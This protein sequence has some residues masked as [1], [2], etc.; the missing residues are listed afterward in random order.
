MSDKPAL[1]IRIISFSELD[2][3]KGQAIADR[4]AK[5]AA[6]DQYSLSLEKDP[7]LLGGLV[8][9]VGDT[10]YDYSIKGQLDQLAS[11]FKDE[12]LP[13]PA[14]LD[15]LPELTPAVSETGQVISYSDGVALVRGLDNCQNNELIEFGSQAQ[16]IAMNLASDHVGVVVLQQ[17]E[18]IRAGM[19]C[20]RTKTTV[21]VPAGLELLGR[22]LDPL[23]QP[24]DGRGKL[25]A[26]SYWPL[27]YPAAG[28]IER[29][30]VN[31]PLQTGITALDAL[32]PIGRGQRELIIG[33][34]QT[35]KTALVIDTIL[36]QKNQ[37]VLCIYVAIGQ[38]MSTVAAVVKLLEEKGAMAYT[39]VVVA[40]ASDTPAMQYV[41]AYAGCAMA[42]ALMYQ[43]KKDVLVVYD[44]LTKHAQ[45][46]RA[47]SLLLRRPP[48]REAYP[49]DIFYLHA[50]LLERSTHLSASL[51][52]GSMTALPVVETQS[53]DISAYIPTN[54]ISITDGQIYLE[55][56]LFFSGQRP[57]V[58][59]GLSVS[60]VGG[61]AQ[62]PA[63]KKVAGPLRINL[64][65]YRSLAAFARF[66]SELDAQTQKQ[67]Q[68][69]ERLLE[70]L[71]QPQY[72]PLPVAEQ[73][74]MLYLANRGAMSD[75]SK[76][77][78]QPFLHDFLFSLRETKADLLQQLAAGAELDE[79]ISRQL[80]KYVAAYLPRWQVEH[81][82]YD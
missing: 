65:Q 21:H 40:S 74:I 61:A 75:L 67:L 64:A 38:K 9:Y 52:G 45:A 60:R 76:E 19:S 16:G 2:Q 23:G 15:Q 28:I 8:I 48:G 71:K 59:A 35:G 7:S 69:G 57:A 24:I 17:D 78:I 22:V 51:G 73:V 70:V 32:T 4:F 66:S 20:Q 10:R 30:P 1:L 27:E 5:R 80:D 63:M 50:R 11:R 81:E 43:D 77:K 31:R 42:E 41:A 12:G 3:V 62:I 49:G 56:E 18:T 54:V 14:S 39:T 53:G 34:R 72:A 36:N 46:Y 58:N 29:E 55:S 6:V 68:I 79:N 82:D 25:Q 47:I 26:S 37:D 13:D 44:D 33:D